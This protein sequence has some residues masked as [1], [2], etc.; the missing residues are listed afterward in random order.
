MAGSLVRVGYR[1]GR[2]RTNRPRVAGRSDGRPSR[3]PEVAP[4]RVSIAESRPDPERRR[5]PAARPAGR[6]L[7]TGHTG[8]HAC[9][10]PAPY[11]GTGQRPARPAT[12][13]RRCHRRVVQPL[14]RRTCRPLALPARRRAPA[15]PRRRA[16]P[17]RRHH[18]GHLAPPPRRRHRRDGG[19]PRAARPR[20]GPGDAQHD[21]QPARYLPRDRRALDLLRAASSSAT[22]RS[23]CWCS[24]T[25]S[26]R[27][28]D[29]EL[30]SP[31]PSAT[32]WRRPS[33]AP[34]SPSRAGPGRPPDFDRRAGRRLS[35]LHGP[36]RSPAAIVVEA[37]RL[38]E[39]DTI[40]VYR[41]I[42]RPAPAS[43]SP[44][45]ARSSAKRPDLATLRVGI[46]E[47]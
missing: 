23:A 5:A 41:V 9:R 19:D 8:S 33:A 36:E 46:G 1:P 34:D 28:T 11:R 10:R 24:T 14:R 37:Q 16:R 47:G 18:R 31:A 20:P 4:N 15:D 44:S 27:W 38:I 26:I 3:T 30:A 17:E 25:A 2:H 22:S 40:R 29:A 6:R 32:T 7:A 13:V 43:R 45:R 42:A 39:L 21:A 35:H 12:P